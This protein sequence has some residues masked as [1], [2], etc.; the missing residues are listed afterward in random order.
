MAVID[1]TNIMQ[2]AII[3]KDIRKTAENYAKAF[4]LPM[5]EIEDVPPV[6]EV[7]VFYRG[8]RTDSRAKICCFHMGNIILELTEPDETPSGW[9]EFLEK[10][11]QGVHHIGIQVND[12]DAALEV[13]ATMGAEVNHVGYYPT[14]SYTFMDSME[15]LGVNLNIKHGGEDNSDKLIRGGEK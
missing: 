9:K 2:I 13:L 1:N 8:E 6:S 11:G 12:R 15:Q 5:P 7:P 10:H 14:G 3:V 4:G